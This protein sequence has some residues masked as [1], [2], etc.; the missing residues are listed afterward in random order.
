[1]KVL[2]G[3]S[4]PKK[5]GKINVPAAVEVEEK[6]VRPVTARK[7]VEKPAPKKAKKVEEN[8]PWM[9]MKNADEGVA[10]PKEEVKAVQ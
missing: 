3:P 8:N 10:A 5:V 4:G 2:T 9:T 6:I 7:E 1:M